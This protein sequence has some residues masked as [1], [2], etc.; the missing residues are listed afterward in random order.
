MDF[1]R[2]VRPNGSFRAMNPE[3]KEFV[4]IPRPS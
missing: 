4:N 2:S 3:V 1:M